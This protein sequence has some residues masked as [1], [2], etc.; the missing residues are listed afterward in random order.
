MKSQVEKHDRLLF[1]K[2]NVREDNGGHEKSA[3][4]EMEKAAL[5]DDGTACGLLFCKHAVDDFRL[6]AGIVL[7]VENG[8]E[9]GGGEMR[10]NFR[11]GTDEVRE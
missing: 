5:C 4:P 11:V 7:D 3:A 8:V 2:E 6:I 9:L 10:L 1:L